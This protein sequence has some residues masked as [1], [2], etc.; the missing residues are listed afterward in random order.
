MAAGRRSLV[1]RRSHRVSERREGPTRSARHSTQDAHPTIT[2]TT[3]PPVPSAPCGLPGQGGREARANERRI[4]LLPVPDTLVLAGDRRQAQG[5][6]PLRA[7][8]KA[9]TI[10]HAVAAPDGDADAKDD[11]KGANANAK[12]ES[13][14]SPSTSPMRGSWRLSLHSLVTES[15]P[16]DT[17]LRRLSG[18]Y[19]AAQ[20]PPRNSQAA[21]PRGPTH[22]R[23]TPVPPR[24]RTREGATGS[25]ECVDSVGGAMRQ[26]RKRYRRQVCGAPPG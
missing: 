2:T 20:A 15:P 13:R 1:A 19:W 24:F 22:P 8:V 3:R 12:A 5:V 11:A 6:G 23:P 21:P 25:G 26:A 4:P 14:R 10:K 18:C 17:R 7:G 9:A 16:P